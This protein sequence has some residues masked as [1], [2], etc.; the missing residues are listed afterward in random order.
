MLIIRLLILVKF[1]EMML[2]DVKCI[3]CMLGGVY[4]DKSMRFYCIRIVKGFF[5]NFIV[6][7]EFGSYYEN[8]LVFKMDLVFIIL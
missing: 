1:F 6:E 7:S 2:M 3:S 4:S 8:F 5:W